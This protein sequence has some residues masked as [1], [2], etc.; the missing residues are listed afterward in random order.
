M[1]REAANARPSAPTRREVLRAGALGLLGL[2]MAEVSA[3]GAL[4]APPGP[5]A[6]S[7]IFIFLTGGLSHLDSFDLKPEAPDSIRGEF[8]PIATRTPG[9]RICEHLP[10]LALRSD[11]WALVRS[12]ATASS[13]HEQACH[14]LL[15]GRLDLPPG[16]STQN[17]PNANEWPS[18][19]AQVTFAR[20]GAGRNHL[21]AALVLPEPSVN[22]AGRVRPGQYAGRLGPRWDAW[23]L[24]VA[25]RCPLGN[26][27]CPHCFRFDGTPFTHAADRIFAPPSLSLPEG[28]APRLRGRL[29]LLEAVERQQRGLARRAEG[30]SL[31]R[32]RR[33]AL[34][35]LSDPRTRQA[36]A[37]DQAD[38]RTLARYGRNKFGLS[39]LMA[40]RLVRAG[41]SLVQV[42]LGKNSSWDTH[43]RNFVNLKDN[44]FP[45]FDRSVSAL[46]DDLAGSGLLGETLV[47]VTGEF[48]RTPR[49]NRDAGRD[50][51]GPVMSLLLAGGGVQGGRVIGASDRIGGQPVADRQTPENLAA[52]LY[53]ALGLPRDAVWHDTDGRPYEL[54]RAAPIPG[55]T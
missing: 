48:G 55:L 32:H 45:Y 16:F 46:L 33:Q 25:A 49:I 38:A 31:D 44:L 17:V 36:F 51:W 6:R 4:A 37:V 10:L 18:L 43:R 14:M 5:R 35:V 29:G 54:Y 19:P 20:R 2:G 47:I 7:V 21:P 40:Y 34:T 13:G 1:T 15:T 22:E 27:A 50:H 11:R 41:V 9:I 42:N 28:G 24:Q 23:H 3:L 8:R 30:Q 53:E 12:V 26:G 52:T 39:L